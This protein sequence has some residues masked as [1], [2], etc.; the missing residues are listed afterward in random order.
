M[1][2]AVLGEGA[3]IDSVENFGSRVQESLVS[4]M[5]MFIGL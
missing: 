5:V 3:F 4:L 1:R 2:Q